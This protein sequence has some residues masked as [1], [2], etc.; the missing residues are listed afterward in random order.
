[1]EKILLALLMREKYDDDN[2]LVIDTDFAVTYVGKIE[3]FL[4]SKGISYNDVKGMNRV[5]D[6]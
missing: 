5:F 2:W 6:N 3:A 4:S 1:M